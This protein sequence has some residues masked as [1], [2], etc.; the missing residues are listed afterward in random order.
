M[1]K[2]TDLNMNSEFKPPDLPI[3]WIAVT[4]LAPLVVILIPAL[5]KSTNYDFKF[6]LI[7]A[8][9]VLAVFLFVT[10]LT[11]IFRIYDSSFMLQGQKRELDQLLIKQNILEDKIDY[12]NNRIELIMTSQRN[13]VAALQHEINDIQLESK[14]ILSDIEQSS[15]N[16]QHKP[17]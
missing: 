11:C 3:A 14:N 12:I 7:I 5:I 4:F 9:A 6:T 2:K 13:N 16:T 15:N 1:E 17:E 8:L 10:C